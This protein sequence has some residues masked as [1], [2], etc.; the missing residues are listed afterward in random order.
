VIE[1]ARGTSAENGFAMAALLVMMSVMAIAMTVA[2]PVWHTATQREKEAELI[3]RGE[4]YARAIALFQRRFPGATPPDIDTLVNLRLL[5]KKYKDPITG[6]DF[7]VVGPAD[8]IA[9]QGPEG[10]AARGLRA[11]GSPPPPGGTA[12][13]G[14]RT[15]GIGAGSTSTSTFSV[16]QP[17]VAGGN[18]SVGGMTIGPGGSNISANMTVRGPGNAGGGVVGVVSTSKDT[19]FRLYNGRNHYNEWVFMATQQTLRAGAGGRGG[20]AGGRGA[21]QPGVNT[22]GGRGGRGGLGAPGPQFPGAPPGTS[23][24]R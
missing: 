20:A 17:N 14:G 2:M 6:A 15:S 23:P 22:P 7:Q 12:T 13:A 10:G 4:Q 1:R 19:S 5:R 18:I 3:F 9:L 8:G 11:P 24:I 21:A 16:S